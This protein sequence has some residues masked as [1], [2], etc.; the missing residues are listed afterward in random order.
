MKKKFMIYMSIFFSPFW[1]GFLS[2]TQSSI[3][4][5]GRASNVIATETISPTPLNLNDELDKIDAV[6]A[7]LA[8]QASIQAFLDGIAKRIKEDKQTVL[9][10]QSVKRESPRRSVVASSQPQAVAAANSTWIAP[11][12]CLAPMGPKDR[13]SIEESHRCWDDLIALYSWNHTTAFNKM[14]C[15][16]GGNPY[17]LG[18][19]VT[20][21]GQ[22]YRAE[23]LMQILPGGSHNP[24]INMNQAWGKYAGAGNSWSPWEC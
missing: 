20:I 2:F 11:E 19:W 22:K 6:H 14:F 5:E 8:D 18:T 15:E 4:T 13:K 17:A 7:Y 9:R 3:T 21:K 1:I 24:Y 23:G 12:G 10:R 16:S